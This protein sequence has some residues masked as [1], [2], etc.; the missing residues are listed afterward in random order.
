MYAKIVLLGIAVAVMTGCSSMPTPQNPDEYRKGVAEGAFGTKVDTYIVN[1]PYS[2]VAKVLQE[3]TKECLPARLTEERCV[4]RNC[5]DYQVT[6]KPTLLKDSKKTEL[7]VQWKREPDNDTYLGGKPP[8]DGMYVI[9][10]DA[11]P[12]GPK[13]TKMTVYAPTMYFV[14]MPAAVKHW[15]NGTNLGCPDFTSR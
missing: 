9:V 3:K 14:H 5:R 10:A 11:V 7:H 12:D 8:A 6:Y 13:A 1:R 4:K 2:A 15:V